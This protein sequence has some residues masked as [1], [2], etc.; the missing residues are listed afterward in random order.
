[1]KKTRLNERREISWKLELAGDKHWDTVKGE[2][3]TSDQESHVC[4]PLWLMT[5]GIPLVSQWSPGL[6]TA[7]H[8]V[9]NTSGPHGGDSGR[10]RTA[11]LIGL[12][13]K[14]EFTTELC[15]SQTIQLSVRLRFENLK[16][17]SICRHNLLTAEI[18][19]ISEALCRI[20]SV[21]SLIM[22]SALKLTHFHL[23][24]RARW[25]ETPCI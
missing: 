24:L 22:S 17:H 6:L 3:W 2:L 7:A 15:F 13:H 1:M 4:P 14:G 12:K 16:G 18:H 5:T 9:L 20:N 25:S 23:D 11:D 8:L 21:K 10:R 19:R